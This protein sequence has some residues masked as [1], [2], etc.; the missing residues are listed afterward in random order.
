MSESLTV[1]NPFIP[2]TEAERKQR[3]E[4]FAALVAQHTGGPTHVLDLRVY[5]TPFIYP[6][7]F[8]S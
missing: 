4:T 2:Q 6:S 3:S 7:Y 5:G 8:S 1:A